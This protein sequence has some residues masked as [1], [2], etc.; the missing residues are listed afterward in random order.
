MVQNDMLLEIKA[1][2]TFFFLDEGVVRAVDG[3][4]FDLRRGETLAVVGESGCGKSVTAQSILRIVPPPGRIV[5][6]ELLYHRYAGANGA[7]SAAEVIDLASLDPRGREIRTIR[8]NEIAMVF[9]EPMISLSPVHTIGNQIIESI[10][11][12]QGASRAEAREGAA[13]IL[14][15]VGMPKPSQALDSYPF[16]LSGGMRQRAMIA[17]A[18]ACHPSLLIADEPTTALDVTTQSQILDLMRSLQADMGMAIMYITHDLG[19]VAEMAD[20]AVVM[21]LGKVVERADV[22]T[23]FARPEH[24]YTRALLRSIPRITEPRREW[25]EAIQGMVPDPYNLPPGCPF[26][27]RCAHAVAA[28]REGEPPWIEVEADHWA[29]CI[30]HAG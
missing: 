17:M 21:Y 18:L 4:E 27:P 14:A 22:R 23:L 26:H 11:L 28:C 16:E 30:L 19:V 7:S 5:E 1:L 6:G 10:R 29:R 8:G 20:Q 13:D 24:P 12:H 3:A 25:L 2:K 15:R 9:Q